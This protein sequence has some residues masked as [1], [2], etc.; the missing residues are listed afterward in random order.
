MKSFVG[1]YISALKWPWNIKKVE[2]EESL[3]SIPNN[4]FT[5]MNTFLLPFWISAN[6]SYLSD[7]ISVPSFYILHLI[8]TPWWETA[9]W[10]KKQLDKIYINK[11]SSFN[12]I[13]AAALLIIHNY[14]VQDVK[15]RIKPLF[16]FLAFAKGAVYL[17]E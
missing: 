9:H 15:G 6:I 16:N 2:K 1:L 12:I 11:C 3:I 7:W 14:P 8:S 5:V 17:L 13:C 10:W 4:T